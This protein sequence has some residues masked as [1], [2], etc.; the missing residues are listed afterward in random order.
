[1]FDWD[2]AESSVAQEVTWESTSR[3][4]GQSL[5]PWVCQSVSIVAQEVW[6]G[7]VTSSATDDSAE[8]QSNIY[9]R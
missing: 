7:I 5:N 6:V 9:L 2:S 3:P 8:S 1:M 4:S